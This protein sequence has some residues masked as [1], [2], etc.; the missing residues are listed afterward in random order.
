MINLKGVDT[1]NRKLVIDG[2]KVKLTCW[3]TAGI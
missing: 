1:V 2:K 3:D